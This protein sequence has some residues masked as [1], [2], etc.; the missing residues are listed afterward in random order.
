MKYKILILDIDGTVTNSKKEITPKT[1]DALLRLQENGTIVVIASGR[2]TKGVAPIADE[3]ELQ[4]FGSY[5][6]SFN[7]ARIVNWKTKEDIY[8]KTLDPSLVKRLYKDATAHNIGIMTYEGDTIV[9]QPPFNKYMKIEADITHMPLVSVESFPDYV[10]FPVNKCLLPG[11]PEHLEALEPFFQSKYQNEMNI[12]RSEP[13]FLEAMP[14]NIDKAY[15]LSKLFQILGISR[16][17]SV[18]CGDG[19]NDLTMIQYAGL[20]VAMANAQDS[21]KEVADYITASNDEDGI[22]QVID[23][24]F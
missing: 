18:C 21:V 16:E 22:V 14:K 9:A 12:F 20:G 19:F 8:S 10:N 11:E 17:E 13:F 24:F 7:G 23:T 4:R 3:L 5:V 2:A 6:L 15:G 1:K